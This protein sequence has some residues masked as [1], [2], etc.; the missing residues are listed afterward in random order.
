MSRCASL[1]LSPIKNWWQDMRNV[2][3]PSVNKNR[4]QEGDTKSDKCLNQGGKYLN[5]VV[6][7]VAQMRLFLILVSSVLTSSPPSFTSILSAVFDFPLYPN[8]ISL[9][10]TCRCESKA[11]LLRGRLHIILFLVRCSF[12]FLC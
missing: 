4:L 12:C 7:Q 10:L 11:G 5:S 3:Q 1:E 6:H 9:F 8:R 2:Q